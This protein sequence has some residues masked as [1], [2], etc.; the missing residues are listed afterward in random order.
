MVAAE[1]FRID[2]PTEADVAFMLAQGIGVAA[3]DPTN[4]LHDSTYGPRPDYYIDLPFICIDCGSKELWTA[5]QQKWWYEEAKG[6]IDSTANRCRTCRQIA[7]KK[8]EAARKTHLEGLE[9]KARDS[10]L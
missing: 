2:R 8:K 3:A 7:R 9:K 4:L 1:K 10:N 5:K 6:K